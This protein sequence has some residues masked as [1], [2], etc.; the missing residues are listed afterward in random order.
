MDGSVVFIRWRQCVPYIQKAKKW[1]PYSAMATSLKG[2]MQWFFTK[3]MKKYFLAAYCNIN[4]H[5]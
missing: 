4:P 2:D 5:V 1:L 3:L